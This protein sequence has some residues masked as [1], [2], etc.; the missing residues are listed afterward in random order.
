M[1]TLSG[2]TASHKMYI[3]TLYEAASRKAAAGMDVVVVCVST[4]GL[5]AC[6]R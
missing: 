4:R 6:S 5:D 1:R 3:Y 2:M